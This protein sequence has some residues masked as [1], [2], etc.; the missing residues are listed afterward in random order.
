MKRPD[1]EFVGKSWDKDGNPVDPKQSP[2]LVYL[3]PL[4]PLEPGEE[5]PVGVSAHLLEG[6]WYGAGPEICLWDGISEMHHCF[7]L[8]DRKSL[9]RMV[10]VLAKA[11]AIKKKDPA[12]VAR[13]G[14]AWV[15]G[16]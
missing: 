2:G 6:N 1:A 8:W 14:G 5:L 3:L 11:S 7:P 15:H 13:L 9:P 12:K 16:A 4:L 10:K